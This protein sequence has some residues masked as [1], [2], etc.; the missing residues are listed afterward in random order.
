MRALVMIEPG[1]SAR[2][3]VHDVETPHPG[4]GEITID[5]AYAGLNFMDVMAR[6]GDPGY[7]PSWPYHP[8]LEVAGTVR[9]IGAD[10]VGLSVGDRVAAV[11]A[12]GGLAEIATARA[13]LTVPVPAEV[14]LRTAAAVPLGLATAMLLIAE[15]G[16]FTP[17]D[18]VLVHSASG[19]IGSALAQLVPLLGGGRLIGTVGRADKVAAAEKAG[20]DVAILRDHVSADAIRSANDGRGVDVV[21]DPL[22]TSALALDLDV[23]ATG[24]RIVLFGNASGGALD[25]LPPAG[26]LIGGNI[27]VTGFSHRG[28]VAGAP[29]RVA[30]AVRRTL[31]LLAAGE[32]SFPVTELPA[33][34]DVPEAHDLLAEG[35]GSGKYVVRVRP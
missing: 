19:G 14:S 7:A 1:D 3:Q 27:T 32:L 29:H 24:A 21:L 20:Y 8:G 5:V 33:L 2:S 30:S 22:G 13:G 31:E 25:P 6:R 9:E 17:G 26:R 23:V 16:R 28:L 10:V 34:A 4:P 15:V 35:R 18:S 11:P 12:G